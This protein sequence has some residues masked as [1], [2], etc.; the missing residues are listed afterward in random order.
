MRRRSGFPGLKFP[1]IPKTSFD[2][3]QEGQK[4]CILRSIFCTLAASAHNRCTSLVC[5]CYAPSSSR[6]EKTSE[7]SS[8]RSNNKT[9]DH[10]RRHVSI[11]QDKQVH[12]GKINGISSESRIKMNGSDQT[13]IPIKSNLKKT[14][15][16][17][18]ANQTRTETRKVTW[19]D[20]QG[21]DIA[22]IQEF[23]PSVSDDGE[24]AGV[25]NSC[26]CAIL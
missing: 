10:H 8:D 2:K 17:E 18:E 15:L 14:L 9:R 23:E 21:K 11:T 1:K 6:K 5:S 26:V 20:D 19:P 7:E 12:R 3:G 4:G 16:H 25:R 22:H 13:R 24:L